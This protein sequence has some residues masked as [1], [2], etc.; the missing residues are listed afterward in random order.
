MKAKLYIIATLLFASLALSAQEPQNIRI[1]EDLIEELSQSSGSEID[2]STLYDDL[3]YFSENPINLNTASREDLEKLQ[4]LNDFQIEG[5][6]K[7]Q[8]YA[9]EMHTVYELQ[10]VDGFNKADIRRVLPFVSVS[11]LEEQEL[12]NLRNVLRYGRN[13][14]FLRNQ[15][16]LQE[17]V[18]YS[19]VNEPD[20]LYN[21]N[22][23][24]YYTR[25]QFDYKR[26][27]RAGFTMEKDPGEAFWTDSLPK[28]FD[29]YTAH[30]EIND[31]GMIKSLNIGDYQ[32]KFGQ[33]LAAWS[34]YGSGKSS[35]VMDVRKKYDGLRKYSSTNENMFMR[36]AGITLRKFNTDLTL[37]VSYK[38]I[39][40]GIELDTLSDIER[41]TAFQSTGLHRKYSE[42]QKRK[43]VSELIYGGNITY[44]YHNLKIGATY[45]SYE[46]GVPLEKDPKPYT[47]FDFRGDRNT[48]YSIDYQY[49]WRSLYLFGEEALSQNGGYA[50]LNAAMFNLAPQISLVALHRHYTPDYH[51]YYGMGFGE[52]STT[53]NESGF[54]LG[55]E[56][57]PFRNWKVSAYFDTFKFPW[58]RYRL[59]APAYGNDFFVQT[60]FT[61]TRY[62]EMYVRYKN[63]RSKQNQSDEGTGVEDVI[64]IQKQQFRYHITYELSKHLILKNR[65]E[66]AYFTKENLPDQT[67]FMMYQDINYDVPSF[68]LKLNFRFAVFD[69]DYEARSY[70]YEND[71]LYAFSVPA[72]TGR[73]LRTYLTLRYTIIDDFLDIWLR[74]GLFHYTDRDEVSSGWDL[75]EGPSKSEAKFQIRM[76]F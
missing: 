10:L 37:F 43:S 11:K 17:P 22:R 39:D 24:R 26:K 41:A 18:G 70:A 68:P 67:G 61:P 28:G 59:H 6:L 19:A 1:V 33:G 66:Y 4:F 27:I 25:Y 40:G 60:D 76:K 53:S 20:K 73:G 57:L 64:G 71:I 23:M 44:R 13:T 65:M 14:L 49:S 29:Y 48:N 34:G 16:V 50:L 7:Y 35:Y 74:Y 58:L 63:E 45:F 5:I 38:N 69:A 32:A 2:F 72:Y 47:Q 3:I 51:A 46:F 56:I 12:P 15:F 52:K 9:G 55:T 54:Y 42:L 30:F 62:V 8:R 31:I 75:I 21:G 36:G